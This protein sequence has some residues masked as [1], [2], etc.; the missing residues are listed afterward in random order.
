MS[1]VV[2]GAC[3]FTLSATPSAP[4][5]LSVS[6]GQGMPPIGPGSTNGW[7]YDADNYGTPRL[8]LHGSACLTYLDSQF[9]PQVYEGCVPDHPGQTPP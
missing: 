6:F 7:T 5:Q 4:S 2:N 9:A 8:I 1:G 3:R